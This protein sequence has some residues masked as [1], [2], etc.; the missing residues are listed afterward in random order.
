M[1]AVRTRNHYVPEVY[2]KG[3]A[4]A[5]GTIDC[6]SLLVPAD[7]A[8]LW[9]RR[10]LA[11]VGYRN[12]LYTQ[13]IA[14]Q[15]A[16]DIERWFDREFEAP[17]AD[18]LAA[19][20]AGKRPTRRQRRH[21]VRFLAAQDLR[22]PQ[23]LVAAL[24]R[25]EKDIP[26]ILDQVLHGTLDKLRAAKA[27]GV[28]LKA[29]PTNERARA[30]PVKVS[31]LPSDRPGYKLLKAEV[32]SGR[33]LWHWSLQHALTSTL[34]ILHT[35]RW[36]VVEAARGHEWLTSDNPVVRLGYRGPNDYSLESGWGT[37]KGN[38]LLPLSPKHLL[39]TQIGT[40]E[41]LRGTLTCQMTLQLQRFIALN[42][43]RMLFARQRSRR[44]EKWRPRFVDRAAY[45]HEKEQWR[46]FAEDNRRAERE[47]ARATLQDEP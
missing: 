47:L 3:W 24:Q 36:T 11:A 17:A 15:D 6:Y 44:V 39:F 7:K 14:G 38:I 10:P 8:P 5:A 43:H 18:A 20:R 13:V 31:V 37:A 46:R 25:F 45:Q 4:D 42:A 2:L 23:R 29:N 33:Q 1:S 9:K 40:T 16:D 35:H 34:N 12:H 30:F 32:T 26:P 41:Q 27:A 22:T 19:A 21:L 28:K